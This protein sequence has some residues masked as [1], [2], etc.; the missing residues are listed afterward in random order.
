[1]EPL[2]SF[3]TFDE[4]TSIFGTFTATFNWYSFA[5]WIAFYVDARHD[6]PLSRISWF[7]HGAPRLLISCYSEDLRAVHNVDGLVRAGMFDEDAS[8]HL[9][10]INTLLA[11]SYCQRPPNFPFFPQDLSKS[12]GKEKRDVKGEEKWVQVSLRSRWIK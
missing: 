12:G 1:M 10:L 2:F 7:L 6:I 8:Y 4:S 9:C 11:V 3:P 5:Y